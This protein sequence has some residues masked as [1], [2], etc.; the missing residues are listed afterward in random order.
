[1][2]IAAPF[3][4]GIMYRHTKIS[5]LAVAIAATGAMAYAAKGG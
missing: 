2:Q 4:R 1:V 5:L 3:W